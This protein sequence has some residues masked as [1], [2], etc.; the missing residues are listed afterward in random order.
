MGETR[1]ETSDWRWGIQKTVMKARC[2][3]KQRSA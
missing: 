3:V 2:K 1:N